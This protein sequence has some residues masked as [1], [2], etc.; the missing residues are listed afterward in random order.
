MKTHSGILSTLLSERNQ[1]ECYVLSNSSSI[2]FG[3]RQDYGDKV[4]SVVPRVL[5]RRDGLMGHGAFL[6]Q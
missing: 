4:R 3:K 6:G 5:G 2:T 1:F